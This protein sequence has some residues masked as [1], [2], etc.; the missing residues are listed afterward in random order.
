MGHF[1][2]ELE[3]DNTTSS[4]DKAEQEIDEMQLLKLEK[5]Y[6]SSDYAYVKS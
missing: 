6:S 5:K 1:G 3:N 4:G 2:M